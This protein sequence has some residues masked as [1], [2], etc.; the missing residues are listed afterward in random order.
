MKKIGCITLMVTCL[1][2]STGMAQEHSESE[3]HEPFKKTHS[4]GLAIG[5][6]HVFKG[7]DAEGNKKVL[8]LPMWGFDYN[9]Q[10]SP[11]WMV[12][13]HT[14][15]IIETF[16]V[17]KHLEG[18]GEG[19]VIERTKPIAPAL[20]GFFKPNH[21]W[22]FGLGL[23]GEFAKEE[24]YFLTR[25]AIEYGAEISK[26]WEVFGALQYDFRWNA[27]DTWT[28]G[29]GISRALGKRH[30]SVEPKE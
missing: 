4:M 20:M 18:G 26:G 1:F 5:H 24:D 11:K 8:A 16:E 7:R 3:T 27:Y 17:E 19:E 2:T 28:I 22:N 13:L 21:H 6:A 30:K 14:D 12:G 15:F 23:G 29:I 10:F 9:F 25:A